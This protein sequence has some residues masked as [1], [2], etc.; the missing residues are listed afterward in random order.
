MKVK[1]I[2]KI[3]R[4]KIFQIDESVQNFNKKFFFSR[5]NNKILFVGNLNYLPN[6]LA[7]RDFIK[8]FYQN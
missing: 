5:K 4:N 6:F 7:C 2:K 1:K 8:K 3:Y